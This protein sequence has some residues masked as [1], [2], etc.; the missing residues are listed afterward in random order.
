M[1]IESVAAMRQAALL[2]FFVLTSCVRSSANKN[3]VL[4]SLYTSGRHDVEGFEKLSLRRLGKPAYLGAKSLPTP[5]CMMAALM[6]AKVM[7][8]G[9]MAERNRLEMRVLPTLPT[10]MGNSPK[11]YPPSSQTCPSGT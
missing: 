7:M 10:D 8:A 2:A 1:A 6:A 11:R 9:L 3:G 5:V 4:L